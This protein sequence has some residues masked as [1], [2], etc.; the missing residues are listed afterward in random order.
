MILLDISWEELHIKNK[1]F[2]TWNKQIVHSETIWKPWLN[3]I[4]VL[5]MVLTHFMPLVSDVFRGYR[6]RPVAWN[7][8]KK[9]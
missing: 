2:E 4:K 1:T 8:L 3:W 7:V 9:A 5:E 6:K